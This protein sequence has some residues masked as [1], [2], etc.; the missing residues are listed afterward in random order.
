MASPPI[1][2][3]GLPAHM[4][5]VHFPEKSCA[6]CNKTAAVYSR[7]I[8]GKEYCLDCMEKG[9]GVGEYIGTT[10]EGL[11]SPEMWAL[12]KKNGFIE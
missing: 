4:G 7:T 3:G 11:V 5:Y 2:M 1:N 6:H 9:A 10:L 12:A 8:D